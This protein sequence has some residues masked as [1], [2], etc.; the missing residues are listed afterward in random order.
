MN[1]NSTDSYKTFWG[2]TMA[3]NGQM[4]KLGEGGNHVPE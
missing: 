1:A 3:R 4:A 2:V